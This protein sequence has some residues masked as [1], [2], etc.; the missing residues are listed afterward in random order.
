MPQ[1]FT[2]QKKIQK[3][4]VAV[5]MLVLL[6]IAFVVW[7]GFFK[8]DEETIVGVGLGGR[9]NISI[10]FNILESSFMKDL[11][12]FSEI[13]AFDGIVGRDDPFIPY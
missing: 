6:I 1:A 10:N 13:E 11:R 9:K 7:W 4:L 3:S 8:E 5:L 2:K 12:P